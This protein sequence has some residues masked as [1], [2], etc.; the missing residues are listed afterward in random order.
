[1]NTVIFRL[2]SLIVICLGLLLPSLASA[3]PLT[4]LPFA[5]GTNV[6]CVQGN[7][8][9]YS[10][11]GTL[12]Y[13]YD[14]DFGRG[15]NTSDNPAYGKPLYA[16]FTGQIVS[17][18]RDIADFSNNSSSNS[19]NNGGLGNA[20]QLSVVGPDGITYYVRFAHMQQYSIPSTFRVGDT[21]SQGQL[22]GRI[23]QTGYS[24]TP[25]L[26]MH[27]STS[28]YGASIPFDFVEG[29]VTTS[30]EIR[31][32]LEANKFVVDNTGRVTLGFPLSSVSAST[33]SGTWST[34]SPVSTSFGS[35]YRASTSTGASFR[36]SFRYR[37][38]SSSNARLS[39]FAR[40]PNSTNRDQAARYTITSGSNSASITVDQRTLATPR[41]LGYATLP[42]GL[43]T[44]TVDVN[45]S[46][47]TVCADGIIVYRL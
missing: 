36:W 28:E 29:V 14:F 46:G 13:S 35:N 20:I 21:V 47:N 16:P 2:L 25:H 3:Q 44:I 42:A 38:P 9:H 19:S 30:T 26:H 5:N 15:P 40:C 41:S 24:T 34:Y 45:R 7:D 6:R 11:S 8:G 39:I 4:F 31:S 43:T 33:R 10:H 23:G 1:M 32:Q 22:I 37:V 12:R 27:M 17:L 18:R